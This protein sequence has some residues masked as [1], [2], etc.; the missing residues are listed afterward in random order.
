MFFFLLEYPTLKENLANSM[1]I[2]AGQYDY[3]SSVLWID[4]KGYG[5]QYQ[6]AVPLDRYQV[7]NYLTL[8]PSYQKKPARFSVQSTEVNKVHLMAV[9][10]IS[11]RLN[12]ST[13]LDKTKV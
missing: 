3:D 6:P 10:G 1:M 11:D 7:G 2:L 13:M 9:H 4:W 8:L 5:V 12:P